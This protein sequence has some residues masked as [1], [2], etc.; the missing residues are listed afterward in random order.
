MTVAEAS[1]PSARRTLRGSLPT[2]CKL[3]N[4]LSHYDVLPDEKLTKLG[5]SPTFLSDKIITSLSLSLTHLLRKRIAD[6]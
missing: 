2:N 4:I 6:K 1:A 3:R 5:F